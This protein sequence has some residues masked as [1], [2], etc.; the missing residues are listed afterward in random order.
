MG[1]PSLLELDDPCWFV[2]AKSVA[3]CGLQ[4]SP[5]IQVKKTYDKP[6]NSE[7]RPKKMVRIIHK[8]SPADLKRESNTSFH[9][10]ASPAAPQF[11][12]LVAVRLEISGSIQR[13]IA[14]PWVHVEHGDTSACGGRVQP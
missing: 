10:S 11:S 12:C 13:T 7:K 9:L 2:W 3:L 6:I 1:M 14:D 5:Y 4:G 8:T